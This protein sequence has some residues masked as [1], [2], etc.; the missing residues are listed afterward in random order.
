M[1]AIS[2]MQ[3]Q[4][5]RKSAAK[6]EHAEDSKE[7]EAT[8]CPPL[9]ILHGAGKVLSTVWSST[10]IQTPD[11]RHHTRCHLYEARP[12]PYKE[13]S[14]VFLLSLSALACLGSLSIPFL[15]EARLWGGRGTP[16]RALVHRSQPTP[17]V[18][19][20]THVHSHFLHPKAGKK[21]VEAEETCNQDIPPA[22]GGECYTS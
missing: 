13:E 6:T 17:L 20:S 7:A 3:G 8:P 11:I 19:R 18:S 1:T 10:G 12:F 21:M 15:E 9:I 16:H 5:R 22:S 14:S 2:L 4:Q